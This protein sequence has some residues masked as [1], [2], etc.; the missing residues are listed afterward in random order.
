MP[1]PRKPCGYAHFS[2]NST[3]AERIDKM[4]RNGSECVF[5]MGALHLGGDDGVI[6]LLKMRGYTARQL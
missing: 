2:R 6:R 4:V 3:Q 1:L 5:S